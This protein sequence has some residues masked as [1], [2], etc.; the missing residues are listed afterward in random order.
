LT[1]PLLVSWQKKGMNKK[2]EI[3]HTGTLSLVHIK[4]FY[5]WPFVGA[6]SNEQELTTSFM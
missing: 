1:C 4:I 6:R 2:N 5:T 3:K